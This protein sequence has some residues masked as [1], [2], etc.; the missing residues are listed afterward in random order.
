M[1]GTDTTIKACGA[2][3]ACASLLKSQLVFC[4]M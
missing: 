3:S 2:R 1:I 4:K